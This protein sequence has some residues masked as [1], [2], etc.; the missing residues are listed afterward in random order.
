VGQYP[1]NHDDGGSRNKYGGDIP[2]IH[3]GI[4]LRYDICVVTKVRRVRGVI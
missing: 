1:Q 3:T 2:A 4:K